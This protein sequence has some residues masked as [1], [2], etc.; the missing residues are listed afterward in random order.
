MKERR[1]E[2]PLQKTFDES[3]GHN[4]SRLGFLMRQETQ[5]CIRA[6]GYTITPEQWQALVYLEGAGEKGLTQTELGELV[7]RDKTTVTRLLKGM[8]EGGLV[9]VGR[10]EGEDRR[11][12]RVRVS[13]DSRKMVA[14]IWPHVINHYREKVFSNLEEQEQNELLR[15]MQKVRRNLNDM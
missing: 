11:T 5:K 4:A 3:L 10:G 8:L 9:T 14:E 12:N 13:E 1:F 2:H 6:A 15:L 7:L